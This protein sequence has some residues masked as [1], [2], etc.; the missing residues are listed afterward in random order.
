MSLINYVILEFCLASILHS[1]SMYSMESF[2]SI[3]TFPFLEMRTAVTIPS[4][5][6]HM[7]SMLPERNIHLCKCTQYPEMEMSREQDPG[8]VN[9]FRAMSISCVIFLLAQVQLTTDPVGSVLF[10][11]K[12]IILIKT[13]QLSLSI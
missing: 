8:D 6:S 3:F 5:P 9:S 11:L 12:K 4:I 2:T 13:I 1:Q 7:S 10:S